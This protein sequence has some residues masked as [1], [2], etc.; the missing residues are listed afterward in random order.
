MHPRGLVGPLRWCVEFGVP[1][2][3]K[4]KQQIPKQ[5][6]PPTRPALLGVY[7]AET[8]LILVSQLARA[9]RVFPQR[10]DVRWKVARSQVWPMYSDAIH[11]L[12]PTATAAP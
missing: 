11:T 8:S 2:A 7:G 3:G 10:N 9:V 5:G 1:A 12:F 4:G 6:R